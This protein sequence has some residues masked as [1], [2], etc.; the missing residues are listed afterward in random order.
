MMSDELHEC[1]S[2]FSGKK[3]DIEANIFLENAENSQILVIELRNEIKME[4]FQLKIDH[5]YLA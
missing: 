3:G 4:F 2:A 5:H 1:K